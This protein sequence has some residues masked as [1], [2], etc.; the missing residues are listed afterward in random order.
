MWPSLAVGKSSDVLEDL[1]PLAKLE[2]PFFGKEGTEIFFKMI[3]PPK[4]KGNQKT[5]SFLDFLPKLPELFPTTT[6]TTTTTATPIEELTGKIVK[7]SPLKLPEYSQQTLNKVIKDIS[8][9]D[10]PVIEAAN[11]F[12][13]MAGQFLPPDAPPEDDS[14]FYEFS[15]HDEPFKYRRP[16]YFSKDCNFRLACEVGRQIRSVTAPVQQVILSNKHVQDLHNRY[17]RAMSYGM[18]NNDCD[19]YYC[20]IAQFFGGPQNFAKGMA[21]LANRVANPDLYED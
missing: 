7:I 9:Q 14:A 5:P 13:L 15:H 21:E 18:I 8:N 10:S 4:D 19:R 3:F 17:T 12:A 16:R 1:N 2:L 20:V 6:T 11:Q